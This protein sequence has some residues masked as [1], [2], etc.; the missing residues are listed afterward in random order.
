MIELTLIFDVY[1][2]LLCLPCFIALLTDK[3]CD[4]M[5]ALGLSLIM[6]MGCICTRESININ[7]IKY[8]VKDR[9]GEGLVSIC[10]V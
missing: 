1:L 4:K 9:L 6:K 3:I 5:N 7:G 10:F 8:V 2:C